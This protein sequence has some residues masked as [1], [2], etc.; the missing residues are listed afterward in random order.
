[1]MLRKILTVIATMVTVG[2]ASASSLQCGTGDLSGASFVTCSGYYE[3][4]LITGNLSDQKTVAGILS[5]WYPTLSNVNWVE[6]I[7]ISK[8]NI[9]DFKTELTGITVIGIH[10][11]G[12]GESLQGTAFYVLDAGTSVDKLA[13]NLGGLSNAAIYSIATV[14]PIPEPSTMALMLAGF[15]AVGFVSKR[16]QQLI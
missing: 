6:K 12:A 2:S 16:R 7:D 11:G 14:S 3:G 8:S 5:N 15:A 1:M 10:K 9:I 13:Y 4:N